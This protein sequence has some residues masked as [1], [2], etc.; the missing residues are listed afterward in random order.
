MKVFRSGDIIV[1][2]YSEDRDS[3]FSGYNGGGL[4]LGFLRYKILQ[5]N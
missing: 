2:T 1:L 3:G 5:K 4:D